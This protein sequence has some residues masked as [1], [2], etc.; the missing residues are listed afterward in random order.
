MCKLFLIIC[1]LFLSAA[2]FAGMEIKAFQTAVPAGGR[3]VVLAVNSGKEAITGDVKVS[4]GSAPERLTVEAGGWAYLPIAFDPGQ[5]SGE[6]TVEFAGATLTLP[7]RSDIDLAGVEWKKSFS[8]RNTPD[9]S[10]FAQPGFDDG[11]WKSFAPPAIWQDEGVTQTRCRVTIPESLKGHELY[12]QLGAVDDDDV[13]YVN[14]VRLGSTRGWNKFREYRVP[15]DIVNYGGENLVAVAVNNLPGSGGGISAL[16]LRLTTQKDTR[17]SLAPVT[18]PKAGKIGRPLPVR[19]LHSENGVLKYPEGTE[20]ALWGTN[21]YPMSWHQYNNM[22]TAIREGKSPVGS[23]KEA[24]DTDLDHMKRLGLDVVRVHIFDREMSDISG[25]LQ[26]NEHLDLQDYL[27]AGAVKRD[28]YVYITLIG[29]W[30]SPNTFP[31]S[32]S[33]VYT[34]P[35]MQFNPGAIEAQKT[36]IRDILTHRNPYSKRS[37]AEEKALC[38]MEIM[39]EPAYFTYGDLTSLSYTPQGE[40]GEALDKARELFASMWRDWLKEYG[41]TDSACWFDL[42]MYGLHRQYYRDMTEAIRNTGARQPIAANHGYSAAWE[43]ALADSE[44]DAV[45]NS[46]YP[47]GLTN[48]VDGVNMLPQYDDAGF[49]EMGHYGHPNN[50]RLDGKARVMYEFD[51]DGSTHGAYMYPAMA[52]AFR[53]RGAQIACQFQYDTVA[54]AAYNTDWG[55]HYVNLLYTPAKAVSLAIGGRVFRALPRGAKPEAAPD[56]MQTEVFRSDF[57]RNMSAFSLGGEYLHSRSADR[58]FVKAGSPS[59]ILATGSDDFADYGGTGVWELTVRGEEAR[60]VIEPDCIPLGSCFNKA[61]F[62]APAARLEENAHLFR[63]KLPGW[64]NAVMSRDGVPVEK[65][66]AGFTVTPGEY[67]IRK[68]APGKTG[69]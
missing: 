1:L 23:I 60:L 4:S 19:P 22:E 37:L 14:G 16:P 7:V 68:A 2:A 52:A 5:M 18:L 62:A 57:A 41:L 63:L 61:G 30:S 47:G 46:A 54:T 45:T 3:A 26:E 36:F 59:Y 50:G 13:T 32:F 58:D 53:N 51:N 27:I 10:A 8:R 39:N 15:A 20:V 40:K 65:T 34:K 48:H 69:D 67:V 64:E 9:D 56:Y 66:G 49:L 33:S 42:F 11:D 28:M 25:N 31:G 24:I 17:T 44:I 29:W 43:E 35:E 38:V 55:T 21:Y 6:I 12:L